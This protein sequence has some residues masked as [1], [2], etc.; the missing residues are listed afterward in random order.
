MP[1]NNSQKHTFL[2]SCSLFQGLADDVIA[3]A[4]HVVTSRTYSD[5]EYLFKQAHSA[6][7]IF[8]LCKGLLHFYTSDE[9][10]IDYF[11]G[12]SEAPGT[13]FGEDALLNDV[14]YYTSCQSIGPTEIC[15]MARVDFLNLVGSQ[16]R[17]SQNIAANSSRNLRNL[18]IYLTK[19]S[20]NNIESKVVEVLY[21]LTQSSNA[22]S[23]AGE[24]LI[25]N[26]SQ[27][28]LADMIGATRPSVYRILKKYQDAGAIELTYG[29][30]R[31]IDMGILCAINKPKNKL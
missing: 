27:N 29:K 14:N 12:L 23:S 7:Y 28:N 24:N 18:S 31:I 22:G 13:H 25:I 2:A 15:L 11:I 26:R 16:S 9:E 8:L 21:R 19:F 20:N 5:K 1:N 4:C 6:Q 30:I 10:G 17:A 3:R